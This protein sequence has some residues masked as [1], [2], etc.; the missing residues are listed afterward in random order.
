M[1]PTEIVKH[2]RMACHDCTPTPCCEY[3]VLGSEAADLIEELIAR[4]EAA[5]ARLKEAVMASWQE[6]RSR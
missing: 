3:E 6:R 5:E 4:V 1:T 2:L